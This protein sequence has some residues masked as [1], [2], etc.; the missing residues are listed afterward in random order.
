MTDVPKSQPVRHR[1]VSRMQKLLPALFILAGSFFLFRAVTPEAAATSLSVAST[2]SVSPEL[3]S[4]IEKTPVQNVMKNIQDIQLGQ[5]V[6]GRNPL[7][8]ETQSPS[9]ISPDT[10][11]RV[12][13]TMIQDGVTFDLEF[14]RS[15]EWIQTLGVEPSGT[16]HLQM[17][18]IGLDGQATVDAIEPCPPIEADDGTGRMVVTGTMKHLA[19]NICDLHVSGLSHPIG[20]TTTHPVWSESRQTFVQ[21]EFLQPGEQLKA[22]TGVAA[23]VIS[24]SRRQKTSEYVYNLEVDGEHVYH[25]S[26]SGLLVHNENCVDAAWGFAEHL[27]GFRES[28]ATATG[29][30]VDMTPFLKLADEGNLEKVLRQAMVNSG[31]NHLNLEGFDYEMFLKWLKNGGPESAPL[32]GNRN[33]TN[34]E[35]YQLLKN[36]LHKTTI[37]GGKGDDFIPWPLK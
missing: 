33:V 5:R 34:W 22:T 23:T 36:H 21:A 18:G 24:I 20:L 12:R 26:T 32:P 19:P 10:W 28:I 31:R 30:S 37:Y 14:L 1:A 11:R 7:R 4:D 2:A 15:L 8:H 17:P 27:D 9:N 6:V 25:V 16:I 35:I 29:K 13:L 3:K